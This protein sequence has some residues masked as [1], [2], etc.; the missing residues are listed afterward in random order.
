MRIGSLA[1]P[2]LACLAAAG[3]ASAGIDLPPPAD[4]AT[5]AAAE[6]LFQMAQGLR[7]K[8]KFDDARDLFREVRDSYPGSPLA[9]EAQYLEAECAYADGS[10]T[11]AGELF[12]KFA[13]DRPFS[14]HLPVVERRLYD[15]G[16]WLIE[17]G[18]RGIFGLGFLTTSDDGVNLLRRQQILLPTGTLAD[19]ALWRV[20]R[21]H[22]ENHAYEDAQLVLQ[23]LVRSYPSSE[24][25]LEARFLLGWAYRHDNRG[26]EYDGEKLRRARAQYMEYVNAASADPVRAAEYRDRIDKAREQ[27]Q[28]IDGVLAEKALARARLYTRAGQPTAALH[29]LR[30]AVARWGNTEKGQECARQAESLSREVLAASAP[31]L[32]PAASGTGS[33]AAAPNGGP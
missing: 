21:W 29:V 25:R 16:E 1:A 10:Y 2:L 4:A 19:D 5:L 6:A 9:A 13:E 26:P 27:I 3:C 24:W 33:G 31:S 30:S 17:D 15:I 7:E 28:E 32:A 8:S 23:D 12:A 14:R 11:G 20:G 18:K 22:A